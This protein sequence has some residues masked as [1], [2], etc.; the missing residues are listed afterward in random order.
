MWEARSSAGSVMP[1]G[2]AFLKERINLR[3]KTIP[4]IS[5]RLEDELNRDNSSVPASSSVRV[6]H[7]RLQHSSVPAR[8]A[9][10]ALV[11]LMS[12]A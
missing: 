12:N 11:R 4:P 2:H 3:L 8:I 9:G 6:S 5:I 7:F 1:G 10:A